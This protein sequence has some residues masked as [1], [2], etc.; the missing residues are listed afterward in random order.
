MH[1]WEGN[2]IKQ[3]RLVPWQLRLRVYQY[4]PNVSKRIGLL[5]ENDVD[6]SPL[7]SYSM[8]LTIVTY[9]LKYLKVYINS[10]VTGD[11]DDIYPFVKET[12]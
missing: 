5:C 11:S 7:K 4:V 10:S 1:L 12:P 3:T 2:V 9:V 6:R 8:R